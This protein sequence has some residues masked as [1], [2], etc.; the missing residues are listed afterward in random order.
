MKF[1]SAATCELWEM[2]DREIRKLQPGQ[3][4]RAGGMRGRFAGI[5]RAGVVHVAY[6]EGMGGVGPVETE[7]FSKVRANFVQR[8]P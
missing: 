3:W 1:R 2:S 6:P 5:T 8:N 7:R 4:I